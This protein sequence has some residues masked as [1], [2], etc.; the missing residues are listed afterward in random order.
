MTTMMTT[1]MTLMSKWR[2]E[3]AVCNYVTMC[4]STC[5]RTLSTSPVSKAT[6]Q[7]AKAGS[8]SRA[9]QPVA[10]VTLARSPRRTTGLCRAWSG[11]RG[12]RLSQRGAQVGAAP[13]DCLPLAEP[14]WRGAAPVQLPYTTSTMY[15]TRF[16]HR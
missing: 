11:G 3:A 15:N 2:I 10:I 1:T 8:T 16:A 4:D 12:A 13:P 7:I 14:P 5:L 6:R 9:R